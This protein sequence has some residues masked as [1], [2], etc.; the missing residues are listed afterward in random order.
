[1]STVDYSSDA[2]LDQS[3]DVILNAMYNSS[4]RA[5]RSKAREFED[6]LEENYAQ[7]YWMTRIMNVWARSQDPQ[8]VQHAEQVLDI[9]TKLYNAGYEY[10]KPNTV[11]YNSLLNCLAHSRDTN[12]A[13][14]GEQLLQQ[15]WNSVQTKQ[16]PY[17]RPSTIT[18]SSILKAWSKSKDYEHKGPRAEA[19]LRDQWQRYYEQ[20]GNEKCKPDGRTYNNVIAT[21]SQSKQDHSF[22]RANALVEE[23]WSLYRDEQQQQSKGDHAESMKPNKVTMTF[24]LSSLIGASRHDPQAV[25]RAEE[26]VKNMWSLAPTQPDMKPNAI[27]YTT[28]LQIWTANRDCQNAVDRVLALLEEMKDR[29]YVRGE[30]DFRPS[31][32][33]YA[34]VMEKLAHSNGTDAADRAESLLQ[35]LWNR[36]ENGKETFVHP[37]VDVYHLVIQARSRSKQ[38][39]AVEQAERL[40]YEMI[41]RFRAGDR[42][43]MPNSAVFTTIFKAHA[44]RRNMSCDPDR[45]Q[46][47]LEQM[48][49]LQKAGVRQVAPDRTVI[50]TVMDL[51]TRKHERRCLE[52]AEEVLKTNVGNGCWDR[53]TGQC[54]IPYYHERL[55]QE[56]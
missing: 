40:L 45:I 8:A 44:N 28:L 36:T 25:I 35:E 16:N 29:F 3:V 31:L 5:I 34:A 20:P 27:I 24:L 54:H 32:G 1:M 47:L 17:V 22:E 43:C 15:M 2:A 37:N 7:T 13:L 19:L 51:L 12:A 14:R 30:A 26:I 41:A 9:M 56:S 11:T 48:Y 55:D 53:T 39:D 10:C 46:A 18:Y 23:M 42:R 50:T 38:R 49:Q 6:E 33:A 52:K 4:D 21:W